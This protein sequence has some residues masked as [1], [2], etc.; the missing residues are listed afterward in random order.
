MF[1]FMNYKPFKIKSTIDLIHLITSIVT[2]LSKVYVSDG[3]FLRTV[4]SHRRSKAIA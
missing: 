2:T 4:D 3:K 1:Q